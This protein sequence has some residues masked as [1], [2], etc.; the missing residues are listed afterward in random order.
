MD[1]SRSID[2]MSGSCAAPVLE[3]GYAHSELPKL[4]CNKGVIKKPLPEYNQLAE[5]LKSLASLNLAPL[6]FAP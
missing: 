4:L 2:V 3:D 1:R 5:F 6:I